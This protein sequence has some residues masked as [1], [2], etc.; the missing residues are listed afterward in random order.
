M[1]LPIRSAGFLLATPQRR[2]FIGSLVTLASFPRLVCLLSRTRSARPFLNP[3]R[4]APPDDPESMEMPH[5]IWSWQVCV[6]VVLSVRVSCSVRRL[7]SSRYGT[8]NVKGDHT[9]GHVCVL[10]AHGGIGINHA[11]G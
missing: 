9:F 11:T 4:L 5:E 1:L 10:Y 3:W 7:G 8:N 6:C 2:H